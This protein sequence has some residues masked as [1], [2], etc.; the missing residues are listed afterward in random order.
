[1]EK[2]IENLEMHVG[3]L[4][5]S[6]DDLNHVVLEQ[7]RQIREIVELIAALQRVLADVV[8]TVQ[9]SGEQE[10]TSRKG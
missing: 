2:R 10:D 8:A 7:A 3:Y 1:M 4:Q 6:V 5:K 9:E